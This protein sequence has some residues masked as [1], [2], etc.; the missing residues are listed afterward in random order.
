[1]IPIVTRT[2][3]EMLRLVPDRCAKRV[4]RWAFRAGRRS[5]RVVLPTAQAGIITGV[6]L[7]VARAGGETAPLLLTALG[8]Q[9]FNFDLLQPMAALPVQIYNYAR[10]PY[11]DWHA[12]AWGARARADHPDRRA[13]PAQPLGRLPEDRWFRPVTSTRRSDRHR[14]YRRPESRMERSPHLRHRRR[15]ARRHRN[16][17][18]ARARRQRLVRRSRKAIE[19][20]SLDIAPR[21]V[22]AIIGP[23]GCGKTTFDSLPEPHARGGARRARRGP[24]ELNG[25]DI[26]AP[27]SIRCGCGASSAWSSRSRT[28][29]R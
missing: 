8:N 14:R 16:A 26:Y 23:S 27:T 24:V 4:W 2:V 18:H 10:S 3:E 15:R 11:P 28:R 6:V 1:M 5:L 9:F 13:Q 17:R 22:T 19:N 29:F 7:S 12:K 25:Q 20:V 21:Q